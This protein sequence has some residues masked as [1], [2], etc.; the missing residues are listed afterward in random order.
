MGRKMLG[1][2]LICEICNNWRNLRYSYSIFLS[3]EFRIDALE[4]STEF[5]DIAFRY[6]LD[7]SSIFYNLHFWPGRRFNASLTVFG[8]TT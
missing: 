8:I 2:R 4:K 5:F 7:T 6:K 1:I 3:L